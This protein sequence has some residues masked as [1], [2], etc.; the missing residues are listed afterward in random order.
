ML[1][2]N[3]GITYRFLVCGRLAIVSWLV[4][5]LLCS[6]AGH[7]NWI[8]DESFVKLWPVGDDVMNMRRSVEPVGLFLAFVTLVSLVWVGIDGALRPVR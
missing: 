8:F 3:L 7:T 5:A 6:Y 2:G 4:H 1:N